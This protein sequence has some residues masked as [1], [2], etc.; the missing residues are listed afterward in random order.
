MKCQ[1]FVTSLSNKTL[2]MSML[3][4]M[5]NNEAV[6]PFFSVPRIFFFKE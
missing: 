2:C 6:K 3:K 4:S 1:L 5:K